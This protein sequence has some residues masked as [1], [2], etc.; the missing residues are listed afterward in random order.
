MIVPCPLY[1]PY[2]HYLKLPDG[3]GIVCWTLPK[4]TST[5]KCRILSGSS[6]G[7]SRIPPFQPKNLRQ[8][9]A[10]ILILRGFSIY[11]L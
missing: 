10:G 11:Q 2:R 1:L 3:L 5:S 9:G 6:F 8:T 7:S 4:E